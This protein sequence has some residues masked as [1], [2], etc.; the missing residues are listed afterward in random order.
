MPRSKSRNRKRAR[1]GK[2]KKREKE[3]FI[4][5]KQAESRKK[6]TK[7]LKKYGKVELMESHPSEKKIS[8]VVLDMLKPLLKEADTL[9]DE[10]KIIE[11]GIMA[12][13]MGVVK[14]YSGEEALKTLMKDIKPAIPEGIRDILLQY[15]NRKCTRYRKYDQFI[16]DYEIS[17]IS[18]DSINL[19]VAYESVKKHS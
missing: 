13:N 10:K 7:R 11:M 6:I 16:H 12:W 3:T 15:V 14:T 19:T 17:R 4:S 9:E 8:A 18:G 5:S 1:I 2:Q